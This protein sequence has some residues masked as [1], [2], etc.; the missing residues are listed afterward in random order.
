M[1]GGISVLAGPTG[2]YIMG[3]IPAVYLMSWIS[4][5]FNSETV[6]SSFRTGLIGL[7]VVYVFG[8]AQLS[9]FLNTGLLETFKVGIIPFFW[10]DL[11][12]LLVTALAVDWL[13][14]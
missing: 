9:L 5:S 13:R 7:G 12:K 2:G 3:F 1:A 14:R 4:E 11:V 8:T 6:I 10:V